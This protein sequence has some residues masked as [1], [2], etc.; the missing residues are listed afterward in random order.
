VTPTHRSERPASPPSEP[1]PEPEPESEPE[2]EF[3]P[4][5]EPALEPRVE[6]RWAAGPREVRGAVAVREQVFCCE[7]GVPRA[8]ELDG[9]DGQALHVV[10]LQPPDGRVIGTLR[11]LLDGRCAKVG[12]VAVERDWRNGGIAS[13]MLELALAGAR[14]RGCSEARLASQLQARSLYERAGFTVDSDVFDEAGIPHV[15]MG[16]P[17]AGG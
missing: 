3:A 15:W 9:R 14:Q 17:L 16:R 13:R 5:L 7:Q 12:R 6:V 1:E 4:V 2:P 11:L 8:E 10:A